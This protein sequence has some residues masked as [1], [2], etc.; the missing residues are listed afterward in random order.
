LD[1]EGRVI[2]PFSKSNCI[3]VSGDKTLAAVRWKRAADLSALKDK[4]VRFRFHLDKGSLYAFWVSP[5]KSGASH[6]YVTAGGPGLTGPKDTV[7]KTKENA[8]K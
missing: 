6:G 2:E 4:P 8:T 3:A 1:G 7:G 5:D